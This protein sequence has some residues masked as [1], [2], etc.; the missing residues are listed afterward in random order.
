MHAHCTPIGPDRP[1]P[2]NKM[3]A[4][5][6]LELGCSATSRAVHAREGSRNVR[7]W[8]TILALPLPEGSEVLLKPHEPLAYK[9]CTRA[10]ETGGRYPP[11]PPS[12][13]KGQRSGGYPLPRKRVHTCT[14]CMLARERG[15]TERKD[16]ES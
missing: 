1:Q 15:S 9:A 16:L 11:S 12:G 14:L 5:G 4:A 6:E 8:R 13:E 3:R 7:F 2:V 10:G